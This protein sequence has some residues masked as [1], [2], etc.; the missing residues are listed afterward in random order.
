MINYFS[1]ENF[2]ADVPNE[3]KNHGNPELQMAASASVVHD[4]SGRTMEGSFAVK[5]YTE[6]L[7]P[8]APRDGC[9][10]YLFSLTA[11]LRPSGMD[12]LYSQAT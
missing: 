11:R 3:A 7:G 9:C 2:A 8:H 12:M 5:P 1:K 10:G 4:S 6:E